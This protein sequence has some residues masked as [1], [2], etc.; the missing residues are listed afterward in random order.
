MAQRT[1]RGRPRLTDAQRSA[2]RSDLLASAMDSI[3]DRGAGVS[4]DDIAADSGV[5]KPVI[6][7]H[8]GDRLGLADAIAVVMADGVT[9]VTLQAV[10]RQAELAEAGQG[11]GI[12]FEAAVAA[13]VSSLVDLVE[14]EPAIYG[15]LVRTIRSG[16]RGFFDNALVEVIRERG[17]RLVEFANPN[18]STE[19][20]AVLVDGAFGFLLF[21]IESWKLRRTP[22]RE[23][24]VDTLTKSVVAG[25]TAAAVQRV[26]EN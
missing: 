8:F 14:T 10:Q 18:I 15:F 2:Q 26:P 9:E 13:I 19:T 7:G 4:V 16:E 24:L 6:Y 20:R 11:Q 25:F 12:D 3:R 22:S 23:V 1:R 17:G 21:S 5:S